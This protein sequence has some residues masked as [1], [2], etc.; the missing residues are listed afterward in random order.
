MVR[1]NLAHECSHQL[2]V[3]V[4]CNEGAQRTINDT[5]EGARSPAVGLAEHLNT[6][7]A[8]V[9][10]RL[11][12]DAVLLVGTCRPGVLAAELVGPGNALFACTERERAL[13]AVTAN[14]IR[15]GV[16][17]R[18]EDR[19]V[20]AVL[21]TELCVDRDAVH[22][23][24]AVV[25][26]SA[27]VSVR[28]RQIHVTR[29]EPLTHTVSVGQVCSLGDTTAGDHVGVDD[30]VLVGG[31]RFRRQGSWRGLSRLRGHGPVEAARSE[32]RGH[33]GHQSQSQSS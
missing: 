33:A 8:L 23:D 18:A 14:D 28:G 5:V 13:A 12:P 3:A 17:L 27:R 19:R 29:D 25:V 2:H 11:N 7:A 20:G 1:R 16:R 4:S 9:S 21:V 26:R 6:V 15:E 22:L 24:V 32:A 10:V 30:L 31:R